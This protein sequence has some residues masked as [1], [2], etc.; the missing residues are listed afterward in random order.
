MQVGLKLNNVV[1]YLETA[2]EQTLASI[3]GIDLKQW[4]CLIYTSGNGNT[5]GTQSVPVSKLLPPS[6]STSNVAHS[7]GLVD[8]WQENRPSPLAASNSSTTTT[9]AGSFSNFAGGNFTNSRPFMIGILGDGT[10]STTYSLKMAGV[11]K[12]NIVP[13]AEV[14]GTNLSLK[15]LG[16][17]I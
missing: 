15:M 7:C 5:S 10:A 1:R 4:G 3:S 11:T 17:M 2:D 6:T 16:R 12:N 8:L 14:S 9:G 13:S